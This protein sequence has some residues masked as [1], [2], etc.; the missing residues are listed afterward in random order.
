MCLLIC[1]LI[2]A[3][4]RTAQLVEIVISS[5]LLVVDMSFV[6]KQPRF[7]FYL[8]LSLLILEMGLN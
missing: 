6:G 2:E 3:F 5:I 4:Q 8:F 1:Q 7:L